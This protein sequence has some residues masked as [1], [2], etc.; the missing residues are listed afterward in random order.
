MPND[1][2]RV[3]HLIATNFVGGPEKQILH[4]ASDLRELGWK[5]W[6]GSFRDQAQ[7]AEILDRA[8]GHDREAGEE[9]QHADTTKTA[10][11][12]TH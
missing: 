4:H 2:I 3:L 8:A 9:H 10:P 12:H 6:I 5:I 7:R 11:P 1:S